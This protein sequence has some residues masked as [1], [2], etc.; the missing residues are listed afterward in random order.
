MAKIDDD[1][2][3]LTYVSNLQGSCTA[4]GHT[5]KMDKPV[6]NATVFVRNGDK[7]QAAWHSEVA[8]AEAK[9]DASG[10]KD[11]KAD[12]AKPAD[13]K[14][15]EPKKEAAKPE[16]KKDD[17]AAAPSSMDKKDEAKKDDK[18]AP[19]SNTGATAEAKPDANT[20][21]LAKIE[22]AGWNA[23]KDKDA[24]ALDA[25]AAKNLAWVDPSGK[26]F[27][28]R[29]DVLKAWDGS[30]CEKI[31]KADIK[32]AFAWALSPTVEVLTFEA[33]TDGSCDG[34]KNGPL[35]GASVYVKEG[36]AWKIAF[37]FLEPKKK[38]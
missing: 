15:E 36:D 9:P 37:G 27:G 16:A 30:N 17:K 34:M 20:D 32:D 19:A 13:T 2:Y 28:T 29:A 7:W 1:T 3:A 24:K 22:L 38:M 12:S 18:A 31:T 6:R 26:W 35:E 25:M 23:W 33:T 5:E 8:V 11:E 21:A 4:D 10:K 14:K